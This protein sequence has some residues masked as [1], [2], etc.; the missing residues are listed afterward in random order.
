MHQTG[1]VRLNCCRLH[2]D[3]MGG[4]CWRTSSDL[5][6]KEAEGVGKIFG[7]HL[8]AIS[9]TEVACMTVPTRSIG[10]SGLEITTVAS[11]PERRGCSFG[12]EPQDDDAAL[13]A[14]RRA[15]NWASTGLIKQRSQE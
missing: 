7:E 6:R 4:A 5:R 10:S 13:A 14:M 11:I 2:R 15:M 12:R 9:Q 3:D 1:V 8:F